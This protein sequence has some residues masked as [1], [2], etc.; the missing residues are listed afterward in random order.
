MGANWEAWVNE[1]QWGRPNPV[2]NASMPFAALTTGA[3]TGFPGAPPAIDNGPTTTIMIQPAVAPSPTDALIANESAR[4]CVVGEWTTWSDCSENTGDGLRSWHEVR[5]RPVINPH[6][7]GGL[8][9]LPRVMRRPCPKGG[10]SSSAAYGAYTYGAGGTS[11]GA[12]GGV[13]D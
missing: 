9:C 2:A 6:Y 7:L 5:Y 1:T 8:T 11:D 4:D 10:W 12:A 13:T 3:P